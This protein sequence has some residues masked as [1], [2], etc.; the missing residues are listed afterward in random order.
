MLPPM[1]TDPETRALLAQ[2]AAHEPA[3]ISAVSM[4][5]GVPGAKV[6]IMALPDNIIGQIARQISPMRTK[7]LLSRMRIVWFI[8]TYG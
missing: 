5:E 2:A 3:G 7:I 1:S 6:V 8:P 4:E